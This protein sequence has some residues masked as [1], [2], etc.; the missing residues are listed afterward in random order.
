[1]YQHPSIHDHPIDLV[2]H[3]AARREWICERGNEDEANIYV[4]GAIADFH[5]SA[6]WRTDLGGLHL[7]CILGTKIPKEQKTAI[8]ELLSLINEQLWL[9]SFALCSEQG[10]IL[11]KNTLLVGGPSL[12]EPQC[13]GLLAHA[14]DCCERYYPAFQFVIWGG[15]SPKDALANSIL[16]IH[17]DA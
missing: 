17:G 6:S 9:G 3:I 2:E 14:V 10:D 1:M 4:P 7:G 13:E 5:L 12:T 15:L 16:E 8:H 11:F